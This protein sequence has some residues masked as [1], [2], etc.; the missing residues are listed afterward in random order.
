MSDYAK[1]AGRVHAYTR[2]TE[3]QAKGGYLLGDQQ[4]QLTRHATAHHP[5]HELVLWADPGVSSGIPLAQRKTGLHRLTAAMIVPSPCT[6]SG[7]LVGLS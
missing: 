3:E 2:V 1:P 4:H 5:D 7:R 6:S